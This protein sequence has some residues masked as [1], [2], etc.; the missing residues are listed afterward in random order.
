ML[1]PSPNLTISF[2]RG[3]SVN[4]LFHIANQ[5]S[6][7]ANLSL[8]GENILFACSRTSSG[9]IEGISSWPPD[10][11]IEASLACLDAA[12]GPVSDMSS[13]VYNLVACQRVVCSIGYVKAGKPD[14]PILS[15]DDNTAS[16]FRA[17]DRSVQSQPK[18]SQ[19]GYSNSPRESGFN[20]SRSLT[21]RPMRAD[22]QTQRYSP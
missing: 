3:Y 13:C 16:M 11:A 21:R 17:D 20:L 8:Y 6:G 7:A 12:I 14:I 15:R 18:D 9:V 10:S 4:S 19:W 1:L 2:A 22:S 5:L